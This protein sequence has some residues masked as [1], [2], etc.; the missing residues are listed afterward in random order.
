MSYTIKHHTNSDTKTIL[1]PA[2]FELITVQDFHNELSELLARAESAE[3]MADHWEKK[4]KVKL[5]TPSIDWQRVRIDAAIAALEGILAGSLYEKSLSK[6]GYP[7]Q[8]AA[9]LAIDHADRLITE[10]MEVQE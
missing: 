1:D 3:K 8:R 7:E 6:D 5:L 10:L 2:G 4:A 9:Y